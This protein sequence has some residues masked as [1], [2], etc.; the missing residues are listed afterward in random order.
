MSKWNAQKKISQTQMYP[1][2]FNP[3]ESPTSWVSLK[4]E[5]SIG[6]NVDYL[7]I[8]KAKTKKSTKKLL[9]DIF[10]HT[11]L[12]NAFIMAVVIGDY[13]VSS[14][15][16]VYNP[17]SY[18][19]DWEFCLT[20]I[21]D[22]IYVLDV[23]SSILLK[24]IAW[25]Q[26]NMIENPKHISLIIVDGVLALPYAAGYLLRYETVTSRVFL[27]LR[28]IT[29][30]RLYRLV[31]FFICYENTTR[32]HRWVIFYIKF[33]LYVIVIEHSFACAWYAL[34]NFNGTG[35]GV[36][37]GVGTGAG[38]GTATGIRIWSNSITN[39]TNHLKPVRKWYLITSY[40]STTILSH[41][42][43][44]DLFPVNI[45]ERFLTSIYVV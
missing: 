5:K 42:G 38:T 21:C 9:A 27:L 2:A 7:V 17:P 12:W 32:R 1:L 36:E 31:Y 43:F 15:I 44:G 30:L 3:S 19:F 22:G 33:F 24:I 18:P 8:Q 25:R 16:Y 23:I 37:T 13:F 45:N 26:P 29:W 4:F 28:L 10:S 35:T 34:I 11:I 40:F 6:N 14:T 39:S 41:T 20:L